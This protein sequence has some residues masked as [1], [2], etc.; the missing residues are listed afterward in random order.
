MGFLSGLKKRVEAVAAQVAPSFIDHGKTYDTVMQNKAPGYRQAVPQDVQQKIRT[1]KFGPLANNPAAQENFINRSVPQAEK[2]HFGIKDIGT[3]LGLGVMRSI[4]GSAQGLS[5]LYD[6]ASPGTGTNRLSKGL[7]TYAKSIDQTVNDQGIYKPLYHVTQGATDALQFFGGGAAAKIASKAPAIKAATN[8]ASP[9]IKIASN[10]FAP[11]I[12]KAL[13][14][15]DALGRIASSTIRTAAKPSNLAANAAMTANYTGQNA[16]KGNATTPGQIGQNFLMG[17][18]MNLGLPLAGGLLHEGAHVVPPVRPVYADHV[19]QKAP[20][21][22]PNAESNVFAQNPMAAR[23]A[24]L[25]RPTPVSEVLKDNPVTKL[26]TQSPSLQTLEQ[27]T[28]ARN[29]AKA[30]SNDTVPLPEYNTKPVSPLDKAFRSTRSIIERQG[31][32]GQTL[33]NML[34]G[35]RDTHE[36]YLGALQK[37]MPTVTKLARKDSNRIRGNGNFENFVNATQGLEAPRS[38]EV[39]QAVKEWQAVHPG[40]R[41]RAVNAGLDVGNLGPQYYPHFIDY[42]AIYKDKNMKNAAINHLVQTGQAADSEEALKL[43]SFARDT[44]RNRQFG[45]LEASRVIDLPFYDKTPNSLVSYLNGSTKRITQTETFGKG[46]EKALHLITEAAKQGFDT[47]AMKNAY[48][49]A[50]GAKNYS[51]TGQK[52]MGTIRKYI[53]TTRLGLGALTNISQNTNTGIVTGHMR[54]FASALKQFD[55]KTRAF[56]GDTGVIADAVLSDLKSQVGY[57]SFSQKV[58]GKAINKITAPG[59]GAVEKMNRSIAATAGRDYALRLAQKGDEATLRKLGVTGKI[60]GKSLTEAQQIQAARKVVE[61]TQF[62]VD[63]QDLPGWA[64][65]PGGKLV[66][67]FRTFSYKQGSFVSNEII[68]PAAHGDLKPLARFLAALPVG[69]GLYETKRAISGRPEEE[70]KTKRG[71]QTAQNIGGFGL[72]VDL[73]QSLN[74]L[75]SKYIPSDRRT[76]MTY[77]AFGGPAVAV[78]AQAAGAIG[79]LVQRK[80]TP[81]DESRLQGKVTI[82]KNSDSYTD[83]TPAARFAIQQVPIVGTAI[84]NRLLPFTK[85]SNADAGKLPSP[86]NAS[87]TDKPQTPAQRIKIAMGTPEAQAFLKLSPADQKAQAAVDPTARSFYNTEANI[88]KAFATPDL[89]AEGISTESAKVLDHYQRLGPKAQDKFN[90]DFSSSYSLK[91]A[92]FEDKKLSGTLNPD[93]EYK[94]T[95]DLLPYQLAEQAGAKTSKDFKN[96]TESPKGVFEV[97]DQQYQLDKANDKIS[98]IDDYQK[99]DKLH[100]AQVQ[101]PFSKDAVDIMG[102]SEKRILDFLSSGK[103]SDDMYKELQALDAASIDAGLYK[104]SKLDGTGGS[105]GGGRKGAKKN[106]INLPSISLADNSPKAMVKLSGFNAPSGSSGLKKPGFT[107][108][109]SK[110]TTVSLS[111]K[112]I[113]KKQG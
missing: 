55:P 4:T 112:K 31:E 69:Y 21:L 40:I 66:S 14:A 95:R 62:K 106:G 71:L 47:D 26:S 3:G 109:K 97:M 58:L 10:K 67:Q 92:Q 42:A 54:T 7:D 24:N 110:R 107:I 18:A 83:A 57:S 8:F 16:S 64:D 75:G 39:A 30:S 99:Q 60:T 9:S 56:V 108:G 33:A 53:T 15:N 65:S 19:P 76:S 59:F 104:Y 100:K 80:N 86:T 78:G 48:D 79:D 32:H 82:G 105:G 6:L 11:I 103:V 37:S 44:S 20:H 70:N 93:E 98:A 5:G 27:E 81:A 45:N 94:A 2:P 91:K 111:A 72:V 96:Y 22:L 87:V 29:R 38:P 63:A 73:Y 12:N 113:A 52:T 43:L 28:I 36:Q 35:A 34:Q 1:A 49:I 13:P 77:G 23:I 90:A 88:K 51:A 102:M 85:E 74:P 84:K 101:S 89:H 25:D 50:V 46:D 41:D 68:K 61:K 17:S